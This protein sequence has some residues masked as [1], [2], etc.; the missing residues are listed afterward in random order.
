MK[1]KCE[2]LGMG[3]VLSEIKSMSVKVDKGVKEKVKHCA[4]RIEARTKDA[5]RSLEAVDT[6][7]LS[8]SYTT[9]MT[10]GGRTAEVGSVLLYALFVEFGTRPHFPPMEALESWARRHGFESAWPVCKAIAE[11]GLQARPHLFPAFEATVSDF[12]AELRD[13][14][15][16]GGGR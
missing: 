7:N 8:R 2:L 14:L 5:L 6:G 16:K 10:D 12:L 1:I 9:E 3:E 13:M 11:K 15:E 4:L